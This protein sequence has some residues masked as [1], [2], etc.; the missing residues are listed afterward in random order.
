MSQYIGLPV[1]ACLDPKS[2]YLGSKCFTLEFLTE[3]KVTI[4]ELINAIEAK[5]QKDGFKLNPPASDDEIGVFEAKVGFLLPK[6]FKEFYSFCNGFEC[7]DDIF[8]FIPLHGIIENADYG[9][10]WFHFAEYMIYS[11]MWTLKKDAA[12]YS[13]VN[14]GD[15][16]TVLT[17]SLMEFLEHFLA[18]NVFED[19]GL[20][21]WQETLK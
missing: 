13:I 2:R 14:L 12:T 1:I 5:N 6:D 19:G 21:D 20:Y 11:D 17:K 4:K 16:E 18:G 3:L 9:E 8:N 7:N 15:K 10:T